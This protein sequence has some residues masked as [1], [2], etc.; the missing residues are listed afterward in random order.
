MYYSRRKITRSKKIKSLNALN[1]QLHELCHILVCK[2]EYRHMINYDTPTSYK[3]INTIEYSRFNNERAVVTLQHLLHKKFNLE[4]FMTS[5]IFD[6]NGERENIIIGHNVSHQ[7]VIHYGAVLDTIN[8][9]VQS[10]TIKDI[11]YYQTIMS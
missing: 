4:N 6:M 2:L 10:H 1:I 8:H 5:V 7:L 3:A 11:N 9:D